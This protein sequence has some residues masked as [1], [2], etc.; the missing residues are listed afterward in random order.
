MRFQNALARVATLALAGLAAAEKRQTPP[1]GAIVVA[2]SGGDFTTLQDAVDS[3]KSS[4]TPSTIFIQPGTYTGQT[5]IPKLAAALTIQGSTPDHLD[6]AQNTVVLTNALSA[7]EAG[8]NDQSATLSAKARDL[9]V[10]NV[11]IDNTFPDT[12][13]VNKPGLVFKDSYIEGAIDFIFGNNGNGWV[14]ASGRS[15]DDSNWYVLNRA[16]ITAKSGASVA[17]G[18]SLLGRPWKQYARVVV[19]NSALGSVIGPAGWSTWGSNP[20]TN[21]FFAESGNQ[22]DGA[23]G[24]RV[25][26]AKPLDTPK[27]I[28]D[29]M[30]DWKSW[31]DQDYWKA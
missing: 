29:I 17:T 5:K 25:T 22:G 11:K 21:V 18:A 20:V 2:L 27:K 23:K 14:T 15:T 16:N 13:Y 30:P 6:Y 10:Y 3:I 28:D 1:N 24:T 7:V 4:K 26:W 12:L 31:V 8:G 9:S 19:Q